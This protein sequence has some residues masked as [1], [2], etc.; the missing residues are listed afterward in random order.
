[1]VHKKFKIPTPQRC[2]NKS[3]RFPDSVIE[4]VEK[5]IE[6]T[7]CSFGMFVVEAVRCALDN[8][9]EGDNQ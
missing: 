4:R 8:L 1:M 6:G 3:V 2:T 7:N 9:E 5:A